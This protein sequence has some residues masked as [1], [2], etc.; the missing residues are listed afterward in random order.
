MDDQ[1]LER[2]NADTG[3]AMPGDLRRDS[4]QRLPYRFGF[5]LSVLT[6]AFGTSS[7]R[8]TGTTLAPR[9]ASA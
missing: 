8:A 5:L 6:S 4:L 1:D 2:F 3:F 9:E 7:G